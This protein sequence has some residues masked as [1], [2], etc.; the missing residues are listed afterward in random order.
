M[1]GIKDSDCFYN[2]EDTI[3]AFK[4]REYTVV[5]IADSVNYLNYDRGTTSLADGSVYALFIS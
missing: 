1:I 4:Y 2:D 5:G 3:E